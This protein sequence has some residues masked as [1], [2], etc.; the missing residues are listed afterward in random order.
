MAAWNPTWDS[1]KKEVCLVDFYMVVALVFALVSIHSDVPHHTL[2]PFT[3]IQHNYSLSFTE[4]VSHCT[5]AV[6]LNLCVTLACWTCAVAAVLDII[7]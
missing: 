6:P 2:H 5:F 3:Y 1:V 7:M 4:L